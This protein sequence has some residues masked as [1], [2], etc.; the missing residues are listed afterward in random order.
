MAERTS[1]LFFAVSLTNRMGFW[2]RRRNRD[3][4]LGHSGWDRHIGL[5]RRRCCGC[6]VFSRELRGIAQIPD[7]CSAAD[8]GE[9]GE[10]D[11]QNAEARF[12]ARVLVSMV[13]ASQRELP[14]SIRYE[15]QRLHQCDRGKAGHLESS[16]VP[17]LDGPR[18]TLRRR[19]CFPRVRSSKWSK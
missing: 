5:R 1:Q 9:E 3:I 14:I 10:K 7:Q 4:R 17:A 6:C 16:R 8:D 19:P 15:R 18:E 12:H 11:E 13:A 2:D